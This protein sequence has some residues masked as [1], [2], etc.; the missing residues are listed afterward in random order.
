MNL[1]DLELLADGGRRGRERVAERRGAGRARGGTT[2]SF[3]PAGP[4]TNAPST[5]R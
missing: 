2:I 1:N 3:A 4:A 5:F